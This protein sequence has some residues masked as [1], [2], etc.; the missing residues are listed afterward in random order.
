MSDSQEKMYFY[1]VY[2]NVWFQLYIWT[3]CGFVHSFHGPV[4]P[5]TGI[6]IGFLMVNFPIL[7][8]V[9][10]VHLYLLHIFGPYRLSPTIWGP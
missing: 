9:H 4:F 2:L 7:V 6:F 5:H 3:P 10:L 1:P 8:H